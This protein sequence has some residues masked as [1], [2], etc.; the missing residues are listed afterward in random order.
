MRPLQKDPS[1]PVTL[2]V[3]HYEKIC[4]ILYLM[5]LPLF[6]SHICSNGSFCFPCV[7]LVCSTETAQVCLK[8]RCG[9]YWLKYHWW[10]SVPCISRLS[11]S[12]DLQLLCIWLICPFPLCGIGSQDGVVLFDMI[13]VC[14]KV[15]E[16]FM[17]IMSMRLTFA[18][19][20]QFS[21]GTFRCYCTW[22]CKTKNGL[23]W[24]HIFAG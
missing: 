21:N 17:W 7:T 4:M 11:Q 15:D 24:R 6:C 10:N 22:F 13:D 8:H 20:K 19:P 12:S 3:V 1:L 23:R 16:T 2:L 14:H 18:C 9:K 5:T